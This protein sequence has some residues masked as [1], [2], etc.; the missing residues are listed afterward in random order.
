MKTIFELIKENLKELDL[1]DLIAL[2]TYIKI[3][4]NDALRD[5]KELYSNSSYKARKYL[6]DKG[7]THAEACQFIKDN[8]HWHYLT[9]YTSTYLVY[10]MYTD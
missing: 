8:I 10:C 5:L 1:I 7:F 6:M 4:K 2:E 3:E 9:V